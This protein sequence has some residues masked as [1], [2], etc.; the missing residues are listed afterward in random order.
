MYGS[1]FRICGTRL[2]RC[3]A[4]EPADGPVSFHW[5]AVTPATT[6]SE[7]A[8]T[9]SRTR[10]ILSRPG[11][12]SSVCND[13]FSDTFSSGGL[14]G[15]PR[16]KKLPCPGATGGT[17]CTT[18]TGSPDGA[19]AAQAKQMIQPTIV[20]PNNKFSARIN[21]RFCCRRKKATRAGAK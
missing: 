9:A 19:R 13:A 7:I 1:M 15:C 6:A 12:T 2:I 14:R 4:W 21:Q 17:V 20:Q 10:T 3:L 16:R 11:K 8:A 5:E 18:S